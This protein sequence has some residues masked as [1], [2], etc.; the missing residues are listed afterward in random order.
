LTLLETAGG[1]VDGYARSFAEKAMRRGHGEEERKR[2]T[3][4]GNLSDGA[5]PATT[6]LVGLPSQFSLSSSRLG[7]LLLAV[8]LLRLRVTESLL[9]K[10]EQRRSA[11]VSRI[12]PHTVNALALVRCVALL[13]TG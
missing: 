9:S 1:G 8:E 7:R 4:A 6:K 5:T 3:E 11:A 13:R 2:A 12:L 10:T